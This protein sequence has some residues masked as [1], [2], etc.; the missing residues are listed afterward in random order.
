MKMTAKLFGVLCA[1]CLVFC[2]ACNNMVIVPGGANDNGSKPAVG[3]EGDKDNDEV[4]YDVGTIMEFNGKDYLVTKNSEGATTTELTTVQFTDLGTYYPN[5]RADAYR[6]KLLADYGVTAYVELFDI[7]EDKEVSPSSGDSAL[8]DTYMILHGGKGIYRIRQRRIAKDLFSGDDAETRS[9]PFKAKTN[10]ELRQNYAPNL[11]AITNTLFET[12]LAK[13]FQEEH[14]FIYAG[15]KDADKQ[16]LT[17]SESEL[18]YVVKRLN[19][20]KV[21]GSE[22]NVYGFRDRKA[23]A[24]KRVNAERCWELNHHNANSRFF[25]F[26]MVAD[27]SYRLVAYGEGTVDGAASDTVYRNTL[28]IK[29]VQYDSSGNLDVRYSVGIKKNGNTVNDFEQPT[30]IDNDYVKASPIMVS[31]EGVSFK[32]PATI[33]F[34]VPFDDSS[35]VLNK[36]TKVTF[37]PEPKN[38]GVVYVP[39]TDNTYPY[40]FIAQFAKDYQ[41]V[42]GKDGSQGGQGEASGSEVP[43]PS[44]GK[45]D[46]TGFTMVDS[47]DKLDFKVGAYEVKCI[48]FEEYQGKTK[49]DTM[50]YDV[51]ISTNAVVLREKARIRVYSDQED[52]DIK[53]ASVK[54]IDGYSWEDSTRTIIRT[55][56][57]V[58]DESLSFSEFK[59][60]F[61]SF[62]EDIVEDNYS[63]THTDKKLGSKNGVIQASHTE[64]IV[65]TE[66]EKYYYIITLTPQQ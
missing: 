29:E 2:A 39:K 63:R 25:E 33:T 57:E 28:T 61:F 36:Y 4:T 12:N 3:D 51:E 23:V 18:D 13:K 16:T 48:S 41:T 45:A 21:N 37:V 60:E 58:S 10:D 44:V 22:R 55:Y 42:F 65:K 35:A 46:W 66:I 27:G 9:K 59:E 52:Y 1:A 50:I 24:G 56:T 19:Y 64:T 15:D 14:N 62:P 5:E 20:V 43:E 26:N 30:G 31:V 49:S 11:I 17:Y 47:A 6:K 54:D 8:Y 53:K 32:V 40:E 38:G 7:T 34:S